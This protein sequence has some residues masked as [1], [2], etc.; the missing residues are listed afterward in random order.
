M[1]VV[2]ARGNAHGIERPDLQDVVAELGMAIALGPGEAIVV[3]LGLGVMMGWIARPAAG[4]GDDLAQHQLGRGIGVAAVEDGAHIAVAGIVHLPFA[5]MLVGHIGGAVEA[6][7]EGRA[8]GAAIDREL[9]VLGGG[10]AHPLAGGDMQAARGF[11]EQRAALELPAGVAGRRLDPALHQ[12]PRGFMRGV[13]VAALARSQFEDGEGDPRRVL[14]VVEA[15]DLGQALGKTG[16][17]VAQ[18][19]F[20]IVSS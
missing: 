13:D 17:M 15:R 20:H 2:E 5:A 6:A 18:M 10:E 12:H 14:A 3:D 19:P 11:V 1:R 16:P 8:V 7:G 9:A 4:E